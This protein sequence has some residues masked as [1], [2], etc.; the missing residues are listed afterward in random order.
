[1]FRF[2][3]F[4]VVPVLFVLGNFMRFVEGFGFVFVKI[5]ATDKSVGFGARLSLFVLGFH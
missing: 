5:R 3:L 1:L 2:G 4:F